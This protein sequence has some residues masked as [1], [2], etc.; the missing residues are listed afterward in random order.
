MMKINEKERGILERYFDI[1]E[2]DDSYELENWTDGGVNMIIYISKCN[3]KSV[4]E[5]LQEFVRDFD[6]DEEVDLYRQD[7]SYKENFTIKESVAD[8]ENWLNLLGTIIDSLLEI[9]DEID[10]EDTTDDENITDDETDDDEIEMLNCVGVKDTENGLEI[11]LFGNNKNILSRYNIEINIKNYNEFELFDICY[12]I[13]NNI[14][15]FYYNNN[16]V[17][18]RENILNI[19]RVEVV[20]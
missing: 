11:I 16:G 3:G 18:T 2:N 15:N 12:N 7:K 17:I 13:S 5:Q 4:L 14:K 19:V 10:D 6:L 9:D 8:F 20:K 1:H